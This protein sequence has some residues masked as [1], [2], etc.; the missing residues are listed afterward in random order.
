MHQNKTKPLPSALGRDCPKYDSIS[1]SSPN[2]NLNYYWVTRK[3][4]SRS[5][6]R[7]R[8][9]PS[10]PPLASRSRL[11]AVRCRGREARRAKRQKAHCVSVRKWGS[12]RGGES[13]R[14]GW[15]LA[16][17][18]CGGGGGLSSLLAHTH[19]RDARFVYQHHHTHYRGYTVNREG[20]Q[21]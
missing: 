18:A 16:F 6:S 1:L 12:L 8:R 19:T 15:T 13:V 20:M 10:P 2:Q 7:G 21:I 11:W 5:V 3:T 17:V 14:G 9:Y 4:D